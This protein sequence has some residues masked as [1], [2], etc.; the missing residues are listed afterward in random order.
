MY[1]LIGSDFSDIILVIIFSQNC[2]LIFKN[3]LQAFKGYIPFYSNITKTS[4]QNQI[5]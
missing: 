1:S 3:C 2:Y 5:N 4:Y